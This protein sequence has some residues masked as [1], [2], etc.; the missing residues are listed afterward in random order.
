MGTRAS[1]VAPDH[2]KIKTV[3]KVFERLGQNE[4]FRYIGNVHVGLDVSAQELSALYDAT[5]YA[6]GAGGE[7]ELGIEGEHLPGSHQAGE[8]VGWY[9][10]HPDYADS[11]FDLSAKR[12]IVVGNGNV[13]IDIARILALPVEVLRGTDIADHALAALAQSKIEEVL[14]LGRR[15]P[16]Q[17]AFTPPE[18]RELGELDGVDVVVRDSDLTLDAENARLLE[19]GENPTALR[20]TIELLHEYA[21]R[22]GRNASR[23]VALRFGVS[24]E[25]ILGH[26]SVEAVRVCRNELRRDALGAIVADPTDDLELI[27]AG[28]V[29]SSVGY[30]GL[31]VSG[32]PFDHERGII[33]TRDGRVVDPATKEVVPRT[34]AAGWIK[35]GPTGV[36]GTNKRCAHKTVASVIEDLRSPTSV[37]TRGHQ[38]DLLEALTRRGVD[39]VSYKGWASIDHHERSVGVAHCRPRVK[40]VRVEDHLAKAATTATAIKV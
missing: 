33:P 32:V 19:T 13:A 8:F 36:I 37:E 11:R 10:G 30:R 6:V 23:S 7:R 9:N 4:R 21:L 15:G 25:A 38:H 24:P 20:Q 14:V 35:R 31:A 26:R 40:L 1:R 27:E 34:Y 17:A 16:A 2:P 29:I 18:L 39:V 28:L 12:A 3:T 22:P 5:I